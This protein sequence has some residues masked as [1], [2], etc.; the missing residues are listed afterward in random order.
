MSSYV[1]EKV[2][3][4]ARTIMQASPALAITEVI[5]AFAYDMNDRQY[6]ALVMALT[7]T[8][9]WLNVV[10]EDYRGRALLREANETA[11]PTLSK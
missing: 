4:P 11:V 3:R 6:G 9:S 1:S 2:A 8:F 10:I 5:D 7:I